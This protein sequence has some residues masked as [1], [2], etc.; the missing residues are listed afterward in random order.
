MERPHVSPIRE[1]QTEN[2]CGQIAD[3]DAG[4]DHDS[5][6]GPHLDQP[7]DHVC[8]HRND[9]HGDGVIQDDDAAFALGLHQLHAQQAHHDV[10]HAPFGHRAR[11]HA[12]DGCHQRH[13]GNGCQ[14]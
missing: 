11:Q 1:Q 13:H 5:L 14:D 12:K 8:L 10:A 9:R 3:C 4:I 2:H 7:G 6:D